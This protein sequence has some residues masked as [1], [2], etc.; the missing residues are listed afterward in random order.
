M[1][2]SLFIIRI[3]IAA[4]FISLS[5]AA[6]NPPVE[7]AYQKQVAIPNASWDYKF[8]PTF[9]FE[10]PDSNSKYKVFLIFRYDAA[11]DFSNIWVRLKMKQP[12]DSTFTIGN[13]IETVLLTTDGSRLGNF[14]GGMYEYKVQLTEGN[15]FPS[16]KK[17]GEYTI[18]LEQI[19]RKS[20]LPGLVN[21]G[22]RVERT[23]PKKTVS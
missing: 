19:M 7:T 16:F 9:K 20:P 3:V 13:R 22:L 4:I 8:Q 12:G 14:V 17:S 21:V 15:D 6:C 1:K 10:I 23:Y 11:F 2:N 5:F 18:Q